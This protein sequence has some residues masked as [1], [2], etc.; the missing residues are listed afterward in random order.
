MFDFRPG[1]SHPLWKSFGLSHDKIQYAQPGDI[2]D[3]LLR[4]SRGYN[5]A[6]DF[7][8]LTR[9]HPGELI[10]QVQI[11]NSERN[12]RLDISSTAPSILF[13]SGGFL[14]PHPERHILHQPWSGL[15]FEPGFIPNSL[16]QTF[17]G[18]IDRPILSPS[19]RYHLSIRFDLSVISSSKD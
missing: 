5:H 18:E 13:Y 12:L 1:Q 9:S 14:S 19:D 2:E 11:V 7:T 3:P 8:A 10:H 6:F 16:N 17:N 15:A 4:T